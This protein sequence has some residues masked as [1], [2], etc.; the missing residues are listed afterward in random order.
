MSQDTLTLCCPFVRDRIIHLLYV[1]PSRKETVRASHHENKAN[2]N[3]TIPYRGFCVCYSD[4]SFR[5]P[6]L[7]SF[8]ILNIG[9]HFCVPPLLPLLVDS[10]VTY[11]LCNHHFL[12]PFFD[13]IVHPVSYY[14]FL[15]IRLRYRFFDECSSFDLLLCQVLCGSRFRVLL[16]VVL[17]Q[18]W[19]ILTSLCVG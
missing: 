3:K 14:N 19:Y 1:A 16:I 9:G 6:P 12:L 15:F 11:H 5:S 17:P 8:R 10:W 13:L 7:S 18:N 4:H 2:H